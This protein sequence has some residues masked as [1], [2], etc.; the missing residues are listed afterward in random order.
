MYLYPNCK[1]ETYHKTD[2]LKCSTYLPIVIFVEQSQKWL[3]S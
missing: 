2:E 3:I 1:V